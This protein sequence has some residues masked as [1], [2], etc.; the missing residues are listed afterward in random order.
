MKRMLWIVG[1][2]IAIVWFALFSVLSTL[3]LIKRYGMSFSAWTWL[4]VSGSGVWHLIGALRAA[5]R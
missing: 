4:A 2:I 1:L 5:I 3:A